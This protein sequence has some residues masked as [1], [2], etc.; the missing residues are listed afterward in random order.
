MNDA[1]AVTVAIA[2]AVGMIVQAVAFHVNVPGIALLLVTGYLLGPD[3]LHVVKPAALGSGLHTLV[4]FSVAVILFEG[5]LNLSVAR[6]KRE[7]LVIRRLVLVGGAMTAVLSTLI[8]LGLL[9]WSL[10]PAIL[11]GALVMVTGP[12]VVTPLLRRVRVKRHL[13]TILEAEGII[14]DALGALFA[15]VVLELVTVDLSAQSLALGVGAFFARLG[16]GLL[17]GIVGGGLIVLL[18]RFERLV[19]ERSENV[20]V[21]GLAIATAQISSSVIGD[22]GIVAAVVAGMIVGH[23]QTRVRRELREFKEQLTTMLISML[24]ILLAAGVHRQDLIELGWPAI[25]T[26]GLLM[27]VVRPLAVLAS[28]RGTDLGPREKAFL[29]WLGPR[30][31]IA[32]A[33]ASLFAETM[34]SKGL[35]GGNALR[36]MV[37]VVIA[38]TVLL[39][40]LSAGPIARLLGVSEPNEAGYLIVGANGIGR[41]LG[42]ALRAA[43]RDTVLIDADPEMC[44]LA[45]KE[46]FRVVFG[47]ALEERNLQRAGL[48]TN[49]VVVAITK[50]EGVNAL[51]V[52]KAR[53]EFHVR[54]GIAGVDRRR[55]A[56]D[57]ANV[58]ALGGHVLFGSARDLKLWIGRGD[59]GQV[60]LER[61][62]LGKTTPD[63]RPATE[64]NWFA[65]DLLPAL[66][67]LITR[68]GSRWS[69][70]DET[71]RPQRGDE[72]FVGVSD[73]AADRAHAF[74]ATG[75][76][77]RGADVEAPPLEPAIK[78]ATPT[79]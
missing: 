30:G 70:V 24:F 11:F 63:G 3:V 76:W 51:S 45:E 20:T 52:G 38:S 55:I 48:D 66:L 15:V 41:L 2:L 8:A 62:T 56:L 31:I 42:R 33:V 12:T 79:V 77:T 14:L 72:V 71:W 78:I 73:D 60:A 17:F 21:L 5:G 50:N 36:A 18:L 10:R 7:Q 9:G 39:Q 4:G 44:R 25:V 46:G 13:A 34:E 35:G 6:L 54:R 59:R 64:G 19:P 67:P 57:P 43:G 58:G 23:F 29:A 28:A 65:E 68:R 16:T 49:R 37:F 32:A 40:G 74:L 22:S 47:N 1:A 69:V 26:V 27:F 53:T 75:G 61:W